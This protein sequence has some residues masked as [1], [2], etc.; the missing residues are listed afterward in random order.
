MTD[1]QEPPQK[2]FRT[3]NGKMDSKIDI[4]IDNIRTNPKNLY[5]VIHDSFHEP[6]N[7][8]ACVVANIK[9]SKDISRT[10]ITLNNKLPLKELQHLKRV[11]NKLVLICAVEDLAGNT[12]QE[13][14]DNKVPE[15]KDSLND[16]SVV[17]VPSLPPKVKKQF[18]IANKLWPCN[19]HPN[20]FHEKLVSG[21]FFDDEDLQQHKLFMIVVCEVVKFYIKKY[22]L[23]LN[24]VNVSVVVDPKTESVVA[25][26]VNNN[27]HPIQHAAM[28]A[29]DKVAA[30]QNGG[31]WA[32]N[33]R[34]VTLRGVDEDLEMYLNNRIP[35][36]NFGARKYFSKSEMELD[37]KRYGDVPYLCTGYYVYM[38]KEP[39]LMCSMGLV[40]ARINKVFFCR[41]NLS[42]GALHSTVKVHT[43]K[44][45]NHH[46]E[47][48]TG[49]L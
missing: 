36:L 2:R 17:E 26:S 37:S 47:V 3:E 29:I 34:E 43:I 35:N 39:C 40:H 44:D 16:F 11:K 41:D 18:D 42:S 24:E 48:F 33:T 28:L 15:L 21:C 30:T 13:V 22:N 38:L 8:V 45:L 27:D 5:P 25:V 4:I 46:F 10:I 20:K 14:I 6:V 12:A 9:N 32:D 19:F 1:I 49:F 31:A 23:N 7:T